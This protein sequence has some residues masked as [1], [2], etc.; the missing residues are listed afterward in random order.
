VVAADE[1]N[2]SI[3]EA[4][5]AA[6]AAGAEGALVATSPVVEAV[7][8]TA[9]AAP[10]DPLLAGALPAAVVWLA[11]SS[12]PGAV[13]TKVTEVAGSAAAAVAV[14]ESDT[15]EAAAAE[16]SV[17]MRAVASPLPVAST[18]PSVGFQAQQNTSEVWLLRVV[19][20]LADTSNSGA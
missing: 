2:T 15:E 18:L 19:T 6:S 14:L 20:S 5:T 16:S 7:T 17:Q 11:P 9:A 3:G 1:D 10:A 8:V 4:T 12:A 13:C